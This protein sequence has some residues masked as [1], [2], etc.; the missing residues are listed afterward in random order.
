MKRGIAALLVLVVS[1]LAHAQPS[2][3]L[4]IRWV[5]PTAD[6]YLT[7]SVLLRVVF[8]GE[9]GGSLVE[10]VTFFADGKQVCVATGA[11]A[12]CPWDAG[13]QLQS[14]ALRVVARLKAGGRL[15]SSIRTKTVDYVESVAVDVILANAVVTEGGRFVRGL[16]R[17]AFR[18][19]DESKE[20]RITSFQSTD[21]PIELVLALD[22]SASMTDALPDLQA[23]ATAFVQAL[24]PQ[25]HTTV[26]AFNDEMFTLTRRESDTQAL[27]TAIGRLTAN[28]GT[29]LYDVIARALQMLSRDPGKHA[30]VVFTD[31]DDR[32][33]QSTLEEVQR[34]VADSDAMLFAVG[35]GRGAQIEA[36]KE[37]LETLSEVS[38]G[39]VV[40][41]D[42][43]DK[44]RAS[45]A[46][47]VES[48]TNQYTLGF[49]PD[50]DGREHRIDVRV[51]GRG[52]LKVRARRGY[53]APK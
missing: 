28:G 25:D 46:E 7:S 1:A 6:T 45:F 51:V 44:L 34:L 15:V 43:T 30:I 40:F 20:R 10:D 21:A 49:V 2:P 52:G 8:V 11:K 5:S 24:R 36:L 27:T 32:S 16:E 35:L 13:A 4:A 17:D 33:S 37:K 53:F 41:A 42:K 47:V 22:T 19:L 39:R 3:G 48:L 18:V 29:A 38:G 14:H 50:R 31:G 12:E 9:G 23:A 26:V